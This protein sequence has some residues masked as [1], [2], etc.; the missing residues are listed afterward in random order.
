M[1]SPSAQ[2]T[3]H[4][5]FTESTRQLAQNGTTE[6]HS[7]RRTS[8]TDSSPPQS[9]KSYSDEHAPADSASPAS[10]RSADAASRKKAPEP[11]PTPQRR[12]N[13]QRR[14]GVCFSCSHAVGRA[15]ARR[16]VRINWEAR[17]LGNRPRQRSAQHPHLKVKVLSRPGTTPTARSSVAAR[18]QQRHRAANRHPTAGSRRLAAVLQAGS[19]AVLVGLRD[20]AD[21]AGATSSR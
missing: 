5:T 12:R 9:V 20:K 6:R 19:F 15:T 10:T 3:T 4:R 1:R 11:G 13:V 2:I 18:L 7:A 8:L 14:R 21:L 16:F 17:V